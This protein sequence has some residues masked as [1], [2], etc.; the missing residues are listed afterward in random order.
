MRIKRLIIKKSRKF[1]IQRLK[2]DLS[3]VFHAYNL[4]IKKFSE[5]D[6]VCLKFSKNTDLAK[7]NEI[8]FLKLDSQIVPKILETGTFDDFLYYF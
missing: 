3:M 7:K 5:I 4:S 1:L 6:S 8:L 2:N